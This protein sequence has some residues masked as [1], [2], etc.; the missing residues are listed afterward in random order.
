LTRF[1]DYFHIGGDDMYVIVPNLRHMLETEARQHEHFFTGA[2]A[3]LGNFKYMHGGPGYTISANTLR[4][5]FNESSNTM[6]DN[7]SYFDKCRPDAEVSYED[8]VLSRCI[9][10]MGVR[11]YDSRDL[12]TGRER[13]H[14]FNPDHLFNFNPNTTKRGFYNLYTYHQQL[15]RQTNYSKLG[16]GAAATYSVA[17]HHIYSPEYFARIHALLHGMCE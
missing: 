15:P 9:F 10:A 17:F 16:L 8:R 12:D 1:K 2:W 13:Y 7:K 14:V 4:K 3:K 11:P 6:G 5:F